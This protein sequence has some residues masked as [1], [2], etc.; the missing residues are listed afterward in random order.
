MRLFSEAF[1]TSGAISDTTF[2]HGDTHSVYK[3]TQNT[4]SY[5]GKQPRAVLSKPIGEAIVSFFDGTI[6]CIGYTN[7]GEIYIEMK[8]RSRTYDYQIL[9]SHPV[10]QMW[11]PNLDL[12]QKKDKAQRHH[13]VP[14]IVEAIANGR[15]DAQVY[16]DMLVEEYKTYNLPF[17]KGRDKTEMGMFLLH[18]N[19]Y[20]EGKDTEFEV[21]VDPITNVKIEED[22]TSKLVGAAYDGRYNFVTGPNG[23][24]TTKKSKPK[25]SKKKMKDIPKIDFG[26]PLPQEMFDKIPNLPDYMQIPENLDDV[27][28]SLALGETRSL[29]L[30]GPTGTGKTTNVKLI[31]RDIQLPLISVINCTNG[32]DETALG[33]FVPKGSEFIFFQSE[34]SDAIEWGGAVVFEEINFGDARYMSFLNSLLDDN[35]FVRL[36]NG[37]V[38][39]RHPQFRFFATMNPNYEGTNP[40]NK[41][42]KNRFD[43][44]E[45]VLQISDDLMLEA[46]LK[47]VKIDKKTVEDMLVVMN[48]IQSKIDNEELDTAISIRNIKNWAKR[49]VL[50]GNAL[51][52]ARKTVINPVANFDNELKKEIEDIVKFKFPK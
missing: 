16:F 3:S 19:L 47:E 44:I 25:A 42:L 13:F 18:D 40:L 5:R 17:D 51:E 14:V 23:N 43:D 52:A 30:Y 46:I 6:E 7:E 34:L 1:K 11:S 26:E 35:G 22:M 33:K 29:L 50:T 38:I 21:I 15:A 39:K 45:E 8:S 12:N 2:K 24:K 49:T 10:I 37:K 31:C 20:F 9:Y 28:E 4:T 27:R 32:L 36:D 41:A 48:R